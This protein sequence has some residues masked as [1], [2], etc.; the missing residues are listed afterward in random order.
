MQRRLLVASIATWLCLAAGGG[1]AELNAETA[2]TLVPVGVASSAVPGELIVAFERRVS[3]RDR[4]RA[5]A[6]VGA[7]AK[8]QFRHID[9]VLASV[10]VGERSH[11]IQ[12]LRRDGRVRYAEPNFLLRASAH[13]TIQP[14]TSCG[15]SRTSARR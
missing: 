14:F 11:A 2:S 5:L 13:L 4:S 1:A 15:G 7:V 6:R 12:A 8:K 3:A 9:A 10:P